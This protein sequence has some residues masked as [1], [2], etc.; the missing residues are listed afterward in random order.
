[1]SYKQEFKKKITKYGNTKMVT[2]IY[3]QN[4]MKIHA[5][6]PPVLILRKIF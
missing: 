1:M 3:T 4:A 6:K 5:L 2:K